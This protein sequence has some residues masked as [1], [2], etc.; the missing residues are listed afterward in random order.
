VLH[1]QGKVDLFIEMVFNFPTLAESYKYVRLRLP[2]RSEIA[3]RASAPRIFDVA[4]AGHER[5]R[6]AYRSCR[7]PRG[8]STRRGSPSFA[9]RY[10]TYGRADDRPRSGFC[11]R[12][13]S[14]GFLVGLLGGQL[15]VLHRL[16]TLVVYR[17]AP[18]R[19]SL[20]V[21]I[22]TTFH[23]H[24]ALHTFNLPVAL[25]DGKVE[26]QRMARRVLPDQRVHRG[27]A[28]LVVVGVDPFCVP[29]AFAMVAIFPLPALLRPTGRIV[30]LTIVIVA[31]AL[32]SAS[33]RRPS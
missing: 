1:L 19:F 31:T 21:T 20:G 29:I 11:R 12:T 7:S 3:A 9:Y 33:T 8:C 10:S 4:R 5:S 28:H 32:A 2:R 23:L 13:P 18:M 22:L 27:P 16:L 17:A 25:L 15:V 30:D 26:G 24:L 6:L 14:V